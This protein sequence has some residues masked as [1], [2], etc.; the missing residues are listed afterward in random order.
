M[1]KWLKVL[2][3]VLCCVLV[4]GGGIFAYIKLAPKKSVEV[5]PARNCMTSYMPSESYIY[6]IVT[7]DSSQ[8]IIKDEQRKIV[9]V[10]VF[11]G[12]TVEIGDPL[13]RYDSTMDN[14]QLEEKR[15]EREKLYNTLQSDYKEYLRYAR[16]PY[17]QTL[18]TA[19]PAPTKAPSDASA[20][21]AVHLGMAKAYYDLNAP[22]G[23]DGTQTNPYVFSVLDEDPIPAT[24]IATLKD[25]AATE[26]RTVYALLQGEK[27]KLVLWVNQDGTLGFA[28]EADDPTPIE[29]NLQTPKSG[30]G[31]ELDPF[32][33]SY[34]STDEVDEEFIKIGRAHV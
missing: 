25:K 3:I 4:V 9:E 10:F 2:I 24:F 34:A 14:L 5:V 16:T 28:V 18:P 17:P 23:G 13:V 6:G 30:S 1:K 31:S 32:V 33:Y 7:S 27:S 22:T 21:V 20:G 26:E 11:E 12:D 19:T 29:T 15:L 8:T